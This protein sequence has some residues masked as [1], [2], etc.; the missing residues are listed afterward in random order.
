MF[1][2]FRGPHTCANYFMT[3]KLPVSKNKENISEQT[4]R[5]LSRQC[6]SLRNKKSILK[7][8]D[9]NEQNTG[10]WPFILATQQISC[11]GQLSAML[12]VLGAL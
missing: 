3:S 7:L 5:R 12:D 6:A 2:H 4:S 9:E 1:G 10:I 8:Y 11:N